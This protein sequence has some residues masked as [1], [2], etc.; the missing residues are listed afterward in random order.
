[1]NRIA[2][3]DRIAQTC[4][5]SRIKLII[6]LISMTRWQLSSAAIDFY[7]NMIS[8]NEISI[9]CYLYIARTARVGSKLKTNVK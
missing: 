2:L 6:H 7:P 1:M 9:T 8:T 3:N 5:C 4:F